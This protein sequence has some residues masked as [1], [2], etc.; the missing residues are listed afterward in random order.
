MTYLKSLP[1]DAA[2]LQVF[3]A[4]PATSRPLLEFHEK[5]LRDDSPFTVAE[6]ELMAAY[7][8]GLNECSYCHGVHTRT[9]EAFG[10]PA[11]LLTAL[12]HDLDTAPADERLKPVLRYLRTL[13]RTPSRITEADAA[14]V[15]AAGWDEDALHDAV[16]VCAL[17][18]FMN[19]MVEGLGVSAD[20][21]YFATSGDRLREKGYSGLAQLLDEPA[22]Q[23]S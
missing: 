22:D 23:P 7:V 17:F 19:R 2:L 3:R 14:A 20:E 10:V 15:Y 21:S 4:Y 13:T 11:G 8:S 16:L 9:A 1:S 18:N 6:R 12:L 5:V